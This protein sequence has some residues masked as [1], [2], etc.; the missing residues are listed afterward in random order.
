MLPHE[1][2]CVLPHEAYCVLPHENCLFYNSTDQFNLMDFM[3]SN[4]ERH[5]R[6]AVML[7]LKSSSLKCKV[8]YLQHSLPLTPSVFKP[9]IS[10]SAAMSE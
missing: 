8:R 1:A 7:H 4:K 3:G 6:N 9:L 5:L 10:A 2:Y